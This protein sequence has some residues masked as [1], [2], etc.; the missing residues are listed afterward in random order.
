MTRRKADLTYEALVYVS[1]EKIREYAAYYVDG[2]HM[3]WNRNVQLEG[4]MLYFIDTNCDII[5]YNLKELLSL[6]ETARVVYKPQRHIGPFEEL[7][8]SQNQ[9]TN[10][11]QIFFENNFCFQQFFS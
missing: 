11:F 5:Q 10:S 3:N 6:D 8:V 1:K 9:I 2:D 4:D 7:C